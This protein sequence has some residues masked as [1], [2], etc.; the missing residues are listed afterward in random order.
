MSGGPVGNGKSY[1]MSIRVQGNL[2]QADIR[3]LKKQIEDILKDK[4]NNKVVNGKIQSEAR[5]P[6][7]ATVTL[8]VT[9]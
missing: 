4:V 6:D 3:K 8:N 1:W 9:N 2:D 7:T 5:A